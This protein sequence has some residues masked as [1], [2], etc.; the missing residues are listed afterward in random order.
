[1]RYEREQLQRIAAGDQTALKVLYDMYY[2]RMAR[3]LLRVTGD[4]E[5]VPE[6]INDTWLAVWQGAGEFRGDAGVSIWIF[7]KAWRK[8]THAL[9]QRRRGGSLGG[10]TSAGAE[11]GV[12]RPSE[13][14]AA[15]A[16]LTPEQRAVVELTY[17]FGY[18]CA[19]I[20][21]ILSCPENTVKSRM[22]TARRALGPRLRAESGG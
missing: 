3:F 16:G 22:Y 6:I 17:F 11:R 10:R 15:L 5:L 19:E 13:L 9:S 1:M 7:G 8:A 18:D 2:P 21:A 4:A 14:E 12:G 20:A